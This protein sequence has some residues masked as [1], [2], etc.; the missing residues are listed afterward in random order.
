M[1]DAHDAQS[2][3]RHLAAHAAQHLKSTSWFMLPEQ[4][5]LCEMRKTRAVNQMAAH[6]EASGSTSAATAAAVTD[7]CRQVPLQANW[8]APLGLRLYSHL[9]V[10]QSGVRPPTENVGGAKSSLAKKSKGKLT[11]CPCTS[12]KAAASTAVGSLVQSPVR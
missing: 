5:P 8:R 12:D 11:R 10:K 4:R 6:R 1:Q 7:T 9:H 3:V 2:I